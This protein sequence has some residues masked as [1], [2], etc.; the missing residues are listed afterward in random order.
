MKWWKAIL[1]ILFVLLLTGMLWV[2]WFTGFSEISL[3]PQ[4]QNSNFSLDLNPQTVQFYENM[5][6]RTPR[7]PYE[8]SSLCTLQKKADAERAFQIL[9]D[10]TILEFY[11]SSNYEFLV[12]CENKQRIKEDFFIAGEGG[13]VNIT[14]SGVFNVILYGEISLIRQSECQNPNV[15]LHEVL[16]A[17]GFDHSEN[18]NN[19]MYGISKCSQTL[20]DDIPSLINEIYSIS[21]YPDLTLEEASPEVHGK[22]LDVNISVRNNGLKLA[23]ASLINIYYDDKIVETIDVPELDVGFGIKLIL[24]NILTKKSNFDE[25]KFVIETASEE[26]DKKNNEIVFES[27]N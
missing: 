18:P 6:Y 20:G 3:S 10:A 7:I 17:L 9:N 11:P 4:P 21:S 13:P 12:S 22:Y 8:I 2:Y 14:Q 26:L 16:H 1:S 24:K 5:R 25:L 23:E 19:I 15:A 27:L